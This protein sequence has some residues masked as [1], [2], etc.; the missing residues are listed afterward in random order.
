MNASELSCADYNFLLRLR[1]VFRCPFSVSLMEETNYSKPIW[2]RVDDQADS[3]STPAVLSQVIAKDTLKLKPRI[4]D[5]KWTYHWSAD[6]PVKHVDKTIAHTYVSTQ[7]KMSKKQCFA[8]EK[9]RD[10][11]KANA[12]RAWRKMRNCRKQCL[13]EPIVNLITERILSRTG[14]CSC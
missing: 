9:A 12:E 2:F 7:R 8:L 1:F 6:Q 4:T 11:V 13:E 3:C 10:T 5:A 14:W